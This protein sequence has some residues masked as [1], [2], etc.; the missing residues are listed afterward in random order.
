MENGCGRSGQYEKD[1][2]LTGFVFRVKSMSEDGWHVVHVPV[3]GNVLCSCAGVNWCSH[4]EATLIFGE[5]SMVP[6]AERVEANKAQILAKG[7]IG[8]PQGWQAT[9]KKNRKWRGLPPVRNT[10]LEK[11]RQ[12]GKP[13]VSIEGRGGAKKLVEKISQEAGWIV[14]KTPIKGCLFHVV[15]N[16]E[17]HSFHA[18]KAMQR[19]IPIAS[20]E[21]WINLAEHLAKI[22]AH[23]IQE[24]AR[25]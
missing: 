24:R 14:T 4:I 23:E 12:E 16:T 22:L 25:T 19:G 10:F 8:P 20:Y 13:L 18:E 2:N 1:G 7:R 5:R 17:T 9:W 6:E 3:K 21:E 11:S 15:E